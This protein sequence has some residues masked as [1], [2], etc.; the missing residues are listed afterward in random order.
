MHSNKMMFGIGVMAVVLAMSACQKDDAPKTASQSQPAVSPLVDF[1]Q[2]ISMK[3]PLKTMKLGKVDTATVTITNTGSEDWPIG[4]AS[5]V[6][7]AYHWIDKSKT[8]VVFD[9]ER[10]VL[11]RELKAGESVNVQATIKSPDQP[12]EYILRLSMVQEH[13]AW[14]DDRGA[15]A[16]NLPVTVK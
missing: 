2:K 15:K 5:P 10:T 6:N 7:L 9:G 11:P 8:I 12:G 3:T 13:V 1:R 14:F 4:G 16:L